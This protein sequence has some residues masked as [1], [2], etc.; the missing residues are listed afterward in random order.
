[1]VPTHHETTPR[2]VTRNVGVRQHR[3]SPQTTSLRHRL[4]LLLGN[5]LIYNNIDIV[6]TS[7][8]THICWHKQDWELS[9]YN[10]DF[11]S[12]RTCACSIPHDL[13]AWTVDWYNLYLTT[14]LYRVK[15]CLDS[16]PTIIL[17][18]PRITAV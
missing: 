18:M 3:S 14:I 1:M 5:E 12:H 10:G 8:K 4:P 7:S 15:P 6:L 2:S 17:E 13:A 9:P 16:L 11:L